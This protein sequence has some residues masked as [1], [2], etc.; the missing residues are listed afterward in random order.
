MRKMRLTDDRVRRLKADDFDGEC[1]WDDR[2][3]GFGIRRR[4]SG[5]QYFF[6]QYRLGVS[7]KFTLGITT[8]LS[9]VA[10]R[11]AAEEI[12]AKVRLGIDPQA[13]RLNMLEQA[14]VTFKSVATKYL[15]HAKAKQRPRTYNDVERHLTMHAASIE[16]ASISSID[17]ARI[18]ALL[19]DI[20]EHRGASAADHVRANLSAMFAWAMKQG[21]VDKNPCINTAKFSPGVSRDRV[22]S[23][24]ELIEV[25]NACGD[26]DFGR[27]VKLLMLTGARRDEIGHAA[28]NEFDFEKAL[29][30]LPAARSKN[31]RPHI[32]HLS[33][34]ALQIVQAI[35]EREES[36]FLLGS[37]EGGFQG[38]S[39]AK[40]SLD[41]RIIRTRKEANSNETLAQWW[42]HD[43]RRTFATRASDLGVLPHVVEAC[44]NHVT[45]TKAGVAG[46]YNRSS[47]A[48]EKRAAF[49]LW[50][51]HI[52]SLIS[53]AASKVLP[54]RRSR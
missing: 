26:D 30:T 17:Q 16:K 32:V 12:V 18:A 48:A 14:A 35:K 20:N 34:L 42:L 38:W 40:A 8:A 51:A 11:E 25:W 39:R 27:A 9:A 49:N 24:D 47:Y 7:R 28:R 13:E 1:I 44:L 36:P 22:L 45:G 10:A 23:D 2:V 50:S 6:V 41:A 37:G 33:E 52:E 53:G 4:E 46:V 3:P 54:F 19:R 29:W 31:H 43:L 21:F 5:K 15:A